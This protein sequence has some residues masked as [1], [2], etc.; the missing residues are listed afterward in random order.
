MKRRKRETEKRRLSVCVAEN[1]RACLIAQDEFVKKGRG[2]TA[3][4]LRFQK[5][6]D[7]RRRK[8][9]DQKKVL[10]P[11]V[12]FPIQPQPFPRIVRHHQNRKLSKANPGGDD[13]TPARIRLKIALCRSYARVT[14]IR[15]LVVNII[16]ITT[17][18]P[19]QINLGPFCRKCDRV[20]QN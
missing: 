6:G 15:D 10:E 18:D 12:F 16:I 8:C 4:S 9:A 14:P 1:T 3:T 20:G 19:T 11:R 13:D 2:S 7:I 17:F 5:S